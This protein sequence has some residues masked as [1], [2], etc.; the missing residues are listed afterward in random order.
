[1]GG[2]GYHR[3]RAAG[4]FCLYR[5]E[6]IPRRSSAHP[7]FPRLG[8]WPADGGG[9]GRRCPRCEPARLQ[10]GWLHAHRDGIL[11]VPTYG[12]FEDNR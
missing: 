10:G 1:M 7:E 12:A 3:V 11:H 5:G 4:T 6:E 8:A 9:D 2:V